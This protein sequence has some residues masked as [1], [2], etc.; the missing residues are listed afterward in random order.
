[1]LH[2]VT[3]QVEGLQSSDTKTAEIHMNYK[4]PFIYDGKIKSIAAEIVDKVG[5]DDVT[6]TS[7]PVTIKK[8]QQ[9]NSLL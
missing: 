2:F 8:P 4:T 1:M 5:N 7:Q 9:I 3:Y 6:H